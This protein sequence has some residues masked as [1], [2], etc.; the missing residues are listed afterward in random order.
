M[1]TRFNILTILL[2]VFV[3]SVNAQS[4]DRF[5]GNKEACG[6]NYTIYYELYRMKNYTDAIPFWQKTIEICPKFSLTLWKNGEKMYVDKIKNTAASP[7]REILLDSLLWIYDQRILHFGNDKRAGKGYVIGRKGL[8]THNY[9]KSDADKAYNLLTQSIKIE[10]NNSKADIILTFMQVS[11]HLYTEGILNPED[12]L[13]DF[14]ICMSI[15]DD[16]LLRDPSGKNF[17]LAKEGVEKHFTKS[18]AANC[19]ALISVYIKQFDRNKT[20]SEWLAKISRHLKTSGCTDSEFYMDLY[21][22]RFAMSPEGGDAHNLA[23]RY[24]K[25][26]NYKD[27]ESFLIM[28]LDLGVEDNEKAQV[29]Y[30]LAYLEFTHFKD[31][32]KAR[33]YA[34]K[35]IEIRPNWGAPYLL[36]GK[37]YIEA[38]TSAF[39]D[40][41]D[42]LTV[43]WVAIDQFAKAKNVDPLVNDKALLLI[44]TYSRHLP[45]TET[46]FY[47]ALKKGDAY[48]VKA[49]INE[50]TTVRARD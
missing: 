2:S 5:G 34:R 16:N 47:Y 49:W 7:K 43:F 10:G 12:V 20:N 44:N 11:R 3:V 36:I 39:S 26:A 4:G 33:D 13:I 24:I 25:A 19:D 45:K 38:R 30:E 1:K 6:R 42:Q 46:L 8:A 40:N 17:K 9:R 14:E 22:A 23:Q 50:K 41:F 21:L 27:A 35:A 18:G 48:L 29:F 15:I 32:K 37:V 31:Y 28:S